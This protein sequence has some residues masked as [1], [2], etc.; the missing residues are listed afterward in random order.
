MKSQ[1]DVVAVCVC[2]HKRP[3]MLEA[4]L[5]SLAIQIIPADVAPQIIVIDNESEPNNRAAVEVFALTCLF[6]VHYV[7]QPK[8]GIAV[9]RNTALD[10]AMALNADWI[11]MLDDDETADSHWLAELMSPEYRHVP[12]LAGRRI[13]VYPHN[14]PP[15]WHTRSKSRQQT[16]GETIESAFTH[17]VRFSRDLLDAKLRFDENIGFMGGE[18]GLFF[19]TARSI[20]FNAKFTRRSKT[21]ECVHLEREG[22]LGRLYSSYW[23]AAER[24]AFK[25]KTPLQLMRITSMAPF[26]IILGISEL[27]LSVPMA[28][29]GPGYFKRHALAGGRRIAKT[30]G[31]VSAILGRLPKPY[32]ITVGS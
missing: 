31:R 14:R 26:H 4:C 32:Q 18:D 2:T 19:K 11:A 9:A 29:L 27:F 24:I 1:P 16:E 13:I 6:P 21:Y 3:K 23:Q 7:H 17:N 28:I 10:K 20:G 25:K 22:Y 8:R 5:A 15:F 30:F 12:V